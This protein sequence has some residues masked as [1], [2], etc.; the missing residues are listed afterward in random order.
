MTT[1][2]TGANIRYI[3]WEYKGVTT[4]PA[5]WVMSSKISNSYTDF[6]VKK[7]ISGCGFG[8]ITI[9]P[10]PYPTWPKSLGSD[11]IRIHDPVIVCRYFLNSYHCLTVMHCT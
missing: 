6:L 7:V 4:L 1:L 10:V 9:S 5:G 3:Q 11:Q 8:F 2:H